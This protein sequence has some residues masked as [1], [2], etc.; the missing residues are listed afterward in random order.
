MARH[1]VVR[2]AFGAYAHS[3]VI[4]DP[5]QVAAVL[6]GPNAGYVIAITGPDPEPAAPAAAEHEGE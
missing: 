6:E 1:L 4:T 5:V 3:E 2:E